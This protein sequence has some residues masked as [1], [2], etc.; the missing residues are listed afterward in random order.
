MPKTIWRLNGIVK[1]ETMNHRGQKLLTVDASRTYLRKWITRVLLN[2]QE[3][4][5][6]PLRV[7]SWS[8][9]V[10]SETPIVSDC[11][12][13]DIRRGKSKA[14]TTLKQFNTLELRRSTMSPEAKPNN[15]FIGNR[16]QVRKT[17]AIE[18]SS[19]A[20]DHRSQIRNDC[21]MT[22]LNIQSI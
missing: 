15:E 3:F 12:C 6:S 9:K 18:N 14:V 4:L 11:F 22:T 17:I 5:H 7:A 8:S 13:L 10:K 1:L 2:R 21:V 16:C 19:L 20:L